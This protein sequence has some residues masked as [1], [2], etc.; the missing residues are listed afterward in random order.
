MKTI[1]KG[2]KYNTETAKEVGWDNNGR[3]GFEFCEEHLYLKRTGEF[4]I[5]GWGG[6]S[7]KYCR[8]VGLN[9]WS[10]DEK[11]IPLT[12]EEARKWAENH[13]NPDEYE[14]IFGEVKE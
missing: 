8:S 9:E 6:P 12:N 13:L 11:I 7:S 10:G 2:R 14:D 5:H 1:I 3:A 4:F